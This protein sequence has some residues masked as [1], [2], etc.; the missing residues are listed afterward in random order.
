MTRAK[1]RKQAEV[2]EAVMNELFGKFQIGMTFTAPYMGGRRTYRV[3]RHVMEGSGS[4]KFTA[5]HS[6][7]SCSSWNKTQKRWQKTELYMLRPE[8]V[9]KVANDPRTQFEAQS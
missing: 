4:G 1:G 6:H 5:T 2:N 3:D 7:I 8:Q 9:V